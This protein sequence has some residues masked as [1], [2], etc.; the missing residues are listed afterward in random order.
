[1]VAL[2]ISAVPPSDKAV[3][4][5]ATREVARL[6]AVLVQRFNSGDEAAFVE[7]V[8][9]YRAKMFQIAM[10]LLR[11]RNDAEEIAQDTFIRAHRGLANFRGESS[12]AAWLY[13][14]ALN[15]SRNRYWY[16]YR[17]RRHVSLPLDAA[18][19]ESNHATFADIVAC[20]A[21]SPSHEAATSEFTAIVA[22][23]MRQL[24]AGQREILNLRNV[25]QLSYRKIGRMLG[26]EIG[27]VKSRIARA[28]TSLRLLLGQSY[29]ECLGDASPFMCF[30]PIRP[31]GNL[32]VACA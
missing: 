8:T 31:T 7:I 30:E 18:F 26:L 10:G 6:D 29:P 9:R 32:R 16:H 3:R 11:N 4:L 17:R 13:R 20:E 27:T 12:L 14:I 15:L 5:A 24:S 22:V 19:S 25:Q 1:M 2:N 23:C 28:R 21:P